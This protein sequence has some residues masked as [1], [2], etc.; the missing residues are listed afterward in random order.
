MRLRRSDP[1]A[2]GLRREYK[3]MWSKLETW[4]ETLGSLVETRPTPSAWAATGMSFS[5]S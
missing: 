2:P 3:A 1:S 5:R 4:E